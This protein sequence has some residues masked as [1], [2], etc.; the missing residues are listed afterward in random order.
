MEQ[1]DTALDDIEED[2]LPQGLDKNIEEK[3]HLIYWS[4]FSDYQLSL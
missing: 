3:Y 2:Q 4:Q 1:P